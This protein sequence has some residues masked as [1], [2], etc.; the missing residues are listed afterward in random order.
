MVMFT[1]VTRS[2]SLHNDKNVSPLYKE[3][4]EMRRAFLKEASNGL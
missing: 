2:I 1:N 3:R 4:V